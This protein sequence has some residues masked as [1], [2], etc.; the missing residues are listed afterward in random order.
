MVVNRYVGLAALSVGAVGL[1][2]S[3]VGAT[4]AV[5]AQRDLE[6]R[7]SVQGCSVQT[8]H[9][10]DGRGHSAATIS[11]IGFGVGVVGLGVASYS[12][13]FRPIFGQSAD[14]QVNVSP[15]EIAYSTRF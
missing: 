7:C 13:L 12:L 4:M 8:A 15:S 9:D 11:T 6:E 5:S 3:G 1:L 10:L 14:V 2:A